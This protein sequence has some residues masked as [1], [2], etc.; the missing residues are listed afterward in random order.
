MWWDKVYRTDILLYTWNLLRKRQN[1]ILP[2]E[3]DAL[4]QAV[5]EEQVE[6][7]NS[8]KD[9][10]EKAQAEEG[11][12]IA[13]RQQANQ[14]ILGL[15]D[16]ASWNQPERYVLYDEDMPGVHRSLMAQ[17]RL[18]QDSAVAI[19]LFPADEFRLEAEPDFA[20]AKQWVLRSLS[21]SRKGVLQNLRAVGVPES[22]KK[23]PLLRNCF[24]LPLDAQGRWVKDAG[25]RLDDDL[26]LVY[27][28]KEAT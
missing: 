25:V 18:G 7:P 13:E 6:V 8:Q 3:I 28:P 23:S 21:L 5:Y 14:A 15:P 17:T 9:R 24:P 11:K 12:A 1:L 19:P 27:E 26:G 20:Q 22:W 16:D 10:M 4:V 2:D